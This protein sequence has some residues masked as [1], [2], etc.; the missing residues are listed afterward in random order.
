[1]SYFWIIINASVISEF[2]VSGDTTSHPHLSTDLYGDWCPCGLDSPPSSEGLGGIQGSAHLC[3]L[4]S[5]SYSD[6]FWS[7]GGQSELM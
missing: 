6:L 2:Q 5:M 4:Q 3:S 7:E 1:M